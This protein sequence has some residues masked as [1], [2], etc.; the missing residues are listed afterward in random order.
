MV[1]RAIRRVHPDDTAATAAEPDRQGIGS[2]H[3]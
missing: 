2:P 1:L 3:R